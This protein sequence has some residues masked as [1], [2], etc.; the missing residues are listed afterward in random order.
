MLE[1]L[2]EYL[3]QVP[4]LAQLLERELLNQPAHA[5]NTED[6]RAH[7]EKLQAKL[8]ERLKA[9]R[10]PYAVLHF[11]ET[12]VN[13][14]VCKDTIFGYYWEINNPVSGKGLCITHRMLH[15]LVA[16]EQLFQNESMQN[17]SG[18]RVG[19]TRLVLD[20]PGLESVL[21]GADVPPDVLDELAQARALQAQQLA[22]AGP[23]VAAGGGH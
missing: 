23:L 18:V 4:V 17:V 8:G 12:E 2:R 15:G 6:L 21:V 20:L 19:E 14:P 22:E 16:H 11:P 5:S 3:R 10:K 9:E 13:C 1:T 7:V